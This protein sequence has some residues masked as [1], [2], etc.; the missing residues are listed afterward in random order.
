MATNGASPE[1]Y[2]HKQ[3]VLNPIVE[4]EFDRLKA[5]PEVRSGGNSLVRTPEQV[6][7]A[8]LEEIEQSADR[9]WSNLVDAPRVKGTQLFLAAVMPHLKR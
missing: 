8:L 2:P 4:K 7:E 6:T 1:T 9:F 3:E 5:D